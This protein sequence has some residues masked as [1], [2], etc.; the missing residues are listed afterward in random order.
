MKRA[1]ASLAVA[2]LAAWAAAAFGAEAD[3]VLLPAGSYTPFLRRKAPN[4]SVPA[5]PNLAAIGAFR[6]D[7]EPV[8]NA[9]FLDFVTAHPE[10]RRSRIKPLDRALHSPAAQHI[11]SQTSRASP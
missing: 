8:T 7:V 4:P 9:E 3:T 2:A 6:L 11:S 1:H 10:W 5:P